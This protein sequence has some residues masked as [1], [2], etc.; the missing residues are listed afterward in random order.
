MKNTSE[1]TS[2]PFSGSALTD[3]ISHANNY[4]FQAVYTEYSLQK[5]WPFL[6]FISNCMSAEPNTNRCALCMYS[7]HGSQYEVTLKVRLWTRKRSD[8]DH[9]S[10]FTTLKMFFVNLPAI[11]F[12]HF[13]LT[14]SM[15]TLQTTLRIPVLMNSLYF[16]T[17]I[18]HSASQTDC[19]RHFRYGG[20]VRDEG[21]E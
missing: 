18:R 11:S 10:L 4:H 8:F 1:D 3:N 6:R 14:S 20:K 13:S 19:S 21:Q 16:H 2:D 7:V 5:M 9:K 15:R 12:F 17:S